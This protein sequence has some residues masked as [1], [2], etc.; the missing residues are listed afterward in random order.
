MI[1]KLMI[2]C[3]EM[4][5]KRADGKKYMSDLVIPAISTRI[6]GSTCFNDDNWVS[7]KVIDEKDV[8]LKCNEKDVELNCHET[9]ALTVE[10]KDL[11]RIFD[12]V[13]PIEYNQQIT[14]LGIRLRQ[15]YL[16]QLGDPAYVDVFV[17]HINENDVRITVLK[18]DVIIND[19]LIDE[20]RVSVVMKKLIV[21]EV[22]EILKCI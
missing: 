19:E 20:Y 17:S 21:N 6:N 3:G 13:V 5:E 18:K 15:P 22:N 16:D 12:M 11:I 4:L 8:E 14:D 9:P 2:G 7:I 10:L 1:K